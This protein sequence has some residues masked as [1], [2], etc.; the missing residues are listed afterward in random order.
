[1]SRAA[2]VQFARAAGVYWLEIFP[3]TRRE[4]RFWEIRAEAI[5]DPALR[6]DARFTLR[7]KWGHS[8]G[9]AAFAT[10]VPRA[11]RRRVVRMAIAY[12]SIVDYLDTT[13]ER[14]VDDPFANTFRLHQALFGAMGLE[15]GEDGDRYAFHPHREDGGYLASQVETCGEIFATLPS[16]P[17]VAGAARRFATLYA[18]A[19]GLCHSLEAGIHD[20][21]GAELT[22]VEADLHPELR[23]GEMLAAGS[24]S[25]PVLALLALAGK[26]GLSERDVDLAAAAYYP[27]ISSLHILLHGVVDQ[28]ADRASGQFNQLNHYESAQDASARLGLI[29]SRARSLALRLP[30]GDLHMAILAGMGGYYLAPRQAWATDSAEISGVVL[31]DLGPLAK[32]ALLVHRARRWPRPSRLNGRRPAAVSN[33]D[34][35]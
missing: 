31:D 28:A 26:P 33:P 32:A 18:E 10:L 27:W 15:P 9:A 17:A 1:M 11:Y 35:S 30:Q 6:R 22:Q 3:L 14:R 24:S 16:A 21:E 34:P 20:I 12:Q 4:R 2:A 8:E 23:W 13:S 29:S 7:T 5:P 25:L 19:Q